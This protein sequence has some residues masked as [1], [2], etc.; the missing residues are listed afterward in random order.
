[1][2]SPRTRLEYENFSHSHISLSKRMNLFLL[3]VLVATMIQ[4]PVWAEDISKIIVKPNVKPNVKT[5]TMGGTPAPSAEV[6]RR[7]SLNQY[8]LRAAKGKLTRVA[9]RRIKL[10]HS[11]GTNPQAVQVDQGSQGASYVRQT[12]V[13][14]KSVDGGL[15][16]NKCVGAALT[17]HYHAFNV[18]SCRVQPARRDAPGAGP[19]AV[20][21]G[22]MA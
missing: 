8:I 1:V 21:G 14:C 19:A 2:T 22:P 4:G 13:L 15:S 17:G 18:E 12:Q 10:P 20:P 9:V 5:A 7:M 16:W 3:F 6:L 11:N